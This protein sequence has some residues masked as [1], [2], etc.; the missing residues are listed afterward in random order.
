MKR[1]NKLL[2]RI[3]SENTIRSKNRDEFI[4][5]GENKIE[6]SQFTKQLIEVGKLIAVENH[7]AENDNKAHKLLFEPF[8]AKHLTPKKEDQRYDLELTKGYKYLTLKEHILLEKELLNITPL[9]VILR[10]YNERKT[11]LYSSE[12]PNVFSNTIVVIALSALLF[13]LSIWW[14]WWFLTLSFFRAILLFIV[15][16]ILGHCGKNLYIAY[17][18]SIAKEY[19][20]KMIAQEKEIDDFITNSTYIKKNM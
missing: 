6:N 14:W 4:F 9:F 10:E 13:Y 19:S 2:T 8:S 20:R 17:K 12:K 1:E 3:K 11:S 18:N 5:C 16:L 15:F 7:S